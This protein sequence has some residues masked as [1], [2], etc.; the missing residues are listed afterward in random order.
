MCRIDKLGSI[1]PVGYPINLWSIYP[2]PRVPSSQFPVLSSQFPIPIMVRYLP[3]FASLAAATNLYATHYDGE[4]Y[5]LSLEDNSLSITSSSKTCGT[6]PSWLTF[7]SSTR[8]IYCSDHAG[9]SSMNGLLTSYSVNQDGSMT[10]L[11]STVDVGAAVHS[12]IFGGK[13]GREKYLAIA[14]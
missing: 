6:H 7:D 5:T 3:F 14:H 1:Y 10:E 4:V 8:T 2:S 12:I 13:D 9:N 11:T